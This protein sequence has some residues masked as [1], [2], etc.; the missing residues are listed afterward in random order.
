MANKEQ[1]HPQGQEDD[2]EFTFRK[3]EDEEAQE[4]QEDLKQEEETEQEK[5]REKNELDEEISDEADGTDDTDD[6]LDPEDETESQIIISGTK[7]PLNG[8]AAKSANEEQTNTDDDQKENNDEEKESK[9][10]R[11]FLIFVG[12]ILLALGLVFA[13]RF[14]YGEENITG[15]VITIDDLHQQNAQG[16]LPADKG[17]MYNGYS[18][19]KYNDVWNT[20]LGKGNTVYDLTFNNDPKSIENI[21]VSGKLD[22]EY[23]DDK[24]LYITFDP[25]GENL[26]WIAVANFGFSRSL[27]VAFN[28]NL[29]AGCTTEDNCPGGRIYTCDDEDKSVVYF[30]DGGETAVI[31][32]DNC[33]IIQGEG[34]EIVRA[35]DRLLM[36]WYGIYT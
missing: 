27:A 23:F 11:N 3:R 10:T 5:K 14:F 4:A 28:Y 18:F 33:V 35:K 24:K 36:R 6:E 34:E 1:N 9:T 16:K 22:K 21:S 19:V 15:K 13:T 12:V 26:R 32:D 20:Q 17:Y 30:K 7:E 31:Y 25:I 2:Q 29:T 8:A